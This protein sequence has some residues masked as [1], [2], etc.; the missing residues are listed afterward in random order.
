[1]SCYKVAP[2]MSPHQHPSPNLDLFLEGLQLLCH[3]WGT[4]PPGLI[5]PP[6]FSR[7]RGSSQYSRHGIPSCLL[8][9]LSP[10]HPSCLPLVGV[11]QTGPEQRRLF[12][13]LEP[14]WEPHPAV[15]EPPW[16]G[17]SS[18]GLVHLRSFRAWPSCL[19][20]QGLIWLCA[21]SPGVRFGARD[22]PV[23]CKHTFISFFTKWALPLPWAPRIT[24]DGLWK[25][26]S[27][28]GTRVG[29]RGGGAHIHRDGDGQAAAKHSK[30]ALRA[31]W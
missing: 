19:Q 1:M 14:V 17:A 8:C 9:L 18:S 25:L 26:D 11:N 3:P 24:V 28:L 20:S 13:R 30:D 15:M 4:I 12:S 16:Q 2:G 22:H 29:R 31:A 6:L 27:L 23:S 7:G 5:L 10:R 21:Q